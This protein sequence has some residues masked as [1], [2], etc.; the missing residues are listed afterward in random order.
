MFSSEWLGV[1]VSL[2]LAIPVLFLFLPEVFLK[3]SLLPVLLV[4]VVSD[5]SLFQRSCELLK[6]IP[7]W[8]QGHWLYGSLFQRQRKEYSS[9]YL[10]WVLQNKHDITKEWI[11]PVVPCVNIH[12]PHLIMNVLKTP[13]AYDLYRSATPWIGTKGSTLASG[14]S[15]VRKH[16]VMSETFSPDVIKRFAQV[17]TECTDLLITKW[18][19]RLKEPIS[20][21]SN[22]SKLVLDILLRCTY[23]FESNCQNESSSYILAIEN[24][25][26]KT[27]DRLFTPVAL[28]SEL[29]YLYCTGSGWRLLKDCR[30][31]HQQTDEFIQKRKQTLDSP[32][33]G[34][35][36]SFTGSSDL[37]DRLLMSAE[38]LT[39]Y[40]IRCEL[41]SILFWGLPLTSKGISWTLYQLAKHPEMQ[42]QCRK[43]AAKCIG[44][45]FLV[46]QGDIAKL[47]YISW[48]IKE[49]LRFHP[50]V[51]EIFRT[52]Y[53]ET[54]LGSYLVPKNA[55]L[56]FKV[57]SLHFNPD[58][59]DEP[60]TFNPMRFHPESVK[61][62]HPYAYMPFSVGPRSCIGEEFA[63]NIIVSVVASIIRK[64]SLELANANEESEREEQIIIIPTPI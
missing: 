20:I 58:Y 37:L 63:M 15:W 57:D 64:F 9:E 7:G 14:R 36:T 10:K 35:H 29:L 44:N 55:T 48:F 60:E 45:K 41:D 33:N 25:R 34:T 46:W 31:V 1:Y 11:G 30:T 12:N 47:K 38:K 52:I 26:D 28:P 56:N 51:P 13:R 6:K 62:Q 49:S 17:Y 8:E 5:F 23:S 54:M 2:L 32:S 3:A 61:D 21:H 18:N 24:V 4:K 53:A 19:E 50:P 27:M 39:D 43:E 40:E 16:K 22:I 59:W 42:K